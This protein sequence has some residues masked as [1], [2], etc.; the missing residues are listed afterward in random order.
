MS[1]IEAMALAM[2]NAYRIKP[3]AASMG[4]DSQI[5]TAVENRVKELRAAL[6][7]AERE[8]WRLVPVEPTEDMKAAGEIEIDRDGYG[9]FLW[10]NEALDVYRAMLA[11]SP[12]AK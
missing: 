10:P 1:V 2:C 5:R 8:G 7:A 6:A 11:A 12:E 4:R 3:D 9:T